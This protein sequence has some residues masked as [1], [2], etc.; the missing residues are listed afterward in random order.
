MP[1]Q[2]IK[3]KLYKN[4]EM[5]GPDMV[6]KEIESVEYR[7][8]LEIGEADICVRIKPGKQLG[9]IYVNVQ[10]EGKRGEYDWC[11]MHQNE[12]LLETSKHLKKIIG[13][14]FVNTNISIEGKPCPKAKIPMSIQ[15]ASEIFENVKNSVKTKKNIN[16]TNTAVLTNQI[17]STNQI[18]I[19]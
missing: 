9:E 13:K 7:E 16:N 4:N 19:Q 6:N 12:L 14:L 2:V 3:K 17:T 5:P 15:T 18:T 11:Q 1:I 8:N 10:F